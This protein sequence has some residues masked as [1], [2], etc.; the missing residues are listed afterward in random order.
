MAAWAKDLGHDEQAL[1]YGERLERAKESFDRLLWNGSYYNTSTGG[2]KRQWVFS[3]ALFG[4][5]LGHVAGFRDLLPT[6]HVR[7][8]LRAIHQYNFGGLDNGAVGPSLQSPP[9]G[10]EGK[11]GGMQIDEV[12]VGSA[13]AAIALMARYGL[14]SEAE[15]VAEAMRRVIYEHGGLQFRTPAAWM[16]NR[17]Y[18]ACMNMRP[19]SVWYLYNT[20]GIDRA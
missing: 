2:E 17:G 16:K 11:E 14:N 10:W 8:H 12:L 18:R 9:D 1:A 20:D 4:I 15:E 13:W 3:D 19:L 6:D 7:G 5:L